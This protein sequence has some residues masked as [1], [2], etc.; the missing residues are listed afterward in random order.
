[1]SQFQKGKTIKSNFMPSRVYTIPFTA[2][3]EEQKYELA[4]FVNEYRSLMILLK[5]KIAPE[6]F[7]ECGGMGRCGTCLIKVSGL[8]DN[9][10]LIRNE[11]STLEKMGIADPQVRLSCQLQIND[12]LKNATVYILGNA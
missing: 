12:D 5:D 6:G 2:F 8:E 7:G 11:Q 1:M 9:S 4:S 3:F 10:E